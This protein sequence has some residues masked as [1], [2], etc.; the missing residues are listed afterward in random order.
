MRAPF[1]RVASFPDMETAEQYRLFSAAEV[2]GRS[3]LYERLS[4]EVADDPALVALLDELPPIKRQ[5]NLFFGAARFLG[6][7]LDGDFR[8]WTIAHWPDV[9]D[10]ML[11]RRTQ[12]NEVGRCAVLLPVLARIPGPLALIEVGASA[13]LCLSLDRYRYVYDDGHAVQVV[14]DG[15]VELRCRTNGRVPLPDRLPEVVWRAGIDLNPLDVSDDDAMRWLETL[16][17]PGQDDRLARLRAAID[18]TRRD[19]PRLVQGDLNEALPGLLAEAPPDAT[20]VVFHSAVLP[21]VNPDD[22]D[23][24]VASMGRLPV[25]WISN[26]AS[27]RLPV[28]AEQVAVPAGRML[29]LVAL[30]G[31]PLAVADPHGAH[32]DWI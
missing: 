11:T 29:F 5:P 30:D 4:A 9:R 13:G 25:R 17:W 22:R 18:V 14:G 20:V 23:R 2:R 27:F 3:A 26:E 10:A 1:S 15:P 31:E 19:P 24:F 32:L 28:L 7:P 12:T 6:A 21:Y 16:V 8:A